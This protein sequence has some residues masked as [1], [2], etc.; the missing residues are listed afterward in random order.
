[1]MENKVILARPKMDEVDL[2]DESARTLDQ[3]LKIMKRPQLDEA[4]DLHKPIENLDLNAQTKT[5]EEREAEYQKARDRILGNKISSAGSVA[6]VSVPPTGTRSPPSNQA[7]YPAGGPNY[8]YPRFHYGVPY[9]VGEHL[10][11]PP[12]P[13]PHMIAG[14]PAEMYVYG[15]SAPGH[16]ATQ[17][18]LVMPPPP[19]YFPQTMPPLPYQLPFRPMDCPP[20]V[21]HVN[22][23]YIRSNTEPNNR[24][25]ETKRNQQGKK[26]TKKAESKKGK[27]IP[28]NKSSKDA[29]LNVN[30]DEKEDI[31]S[32]DTEGVKTDLENTENGKNEIPSVNMKENGEENW[33]LKNSPDGKYAIDLKKAINVSKQKKKSRKS[34]VDQ[35]TGALLQNL[36]SN[37]D[38]SDGSEETKDGSPIKDEVVLEKDALLSELTSMILDKDKKKKKKNNK[39]KKVLQLKTD[40]KTIPSF[41]ASFRDINKHNNMRILRIPK[42]PD[43][44]K[45][46]TLLRQNVQLA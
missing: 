3:T 46:F 28:E 20:P 33:R 34:K 19:H 27:S 43:G 21:S 39:K 14:L 45:G 7:M 32:L 18:P 30:P 26:F 13:P 24:L 11:Y 22:G 36:Q 12:V 25:E 9:D 23:G 29:K 44:T 42:G 2:V 31:K 1:M 10:T 16:N 38:K 17:M 5:F 41:V 15:G 37:L 6:P 35:S 40:E 8:P 4:N